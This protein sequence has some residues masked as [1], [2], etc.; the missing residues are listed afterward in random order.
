MVESADKLRQKS[1][2][3]ARKTT[4]MSPLGPGLRSIQL[5]LADD[6]VVYLRALLEAYD[7]LGFLY[8]EG[9]GTVHIVTTNSQFE[10]LR[11]FVGEFGDDATARPQVI[12]E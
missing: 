9:D 4:S 7:H 5:S 8:G 6:E 12:L 11:E 3:R 10:A 1:A 2:M